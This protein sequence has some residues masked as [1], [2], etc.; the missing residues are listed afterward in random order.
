MNIIEACSIDGAHIPQLVSQQEAERRGK[1]YD[2][3]KLNFL[4]NLSQGIRAGS[5]CSL[6]T[7][8]LYLVWFAFPPGK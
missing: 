1:V 4:F 3:Y 5:L 2:K 7:C 8:S 6:A